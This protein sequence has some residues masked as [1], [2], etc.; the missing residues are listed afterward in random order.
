MLGPKRG[1]DGAVQNKGYDHDR[2]RGE[3]REKQC[4]DCNGENGQSDQDVSAPY[5]VDQQAGWDLAEH[6]SDRIS[7]ECRPDLHLC[8]GLPGKIGRHKGA[9][10]ALGGSEGE[11]QP[12]KTRSAERPVL[13]TTQTLRQL[14]QGR[15]RC[16][17]GSV[18]RIR[19]ADDRSHNSATERP[20]LIWINA[21]RLERE[22]AAR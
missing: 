2:D 6:G 20:A 17:C 8:P 16:V 1:A 13:P 4:S 7:A 18:H 11:V 9:E 15:G 10:P 14:G 19:P 22:G 3:G 5:G 21:G 12:V